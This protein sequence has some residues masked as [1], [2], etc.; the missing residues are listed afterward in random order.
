LIKIVHEFDDEVKSKDNKDLPYWFGKTETKQKIPDS[1][2]ENS[3]A[4]E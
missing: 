2:K 1:I 3:N 4:T